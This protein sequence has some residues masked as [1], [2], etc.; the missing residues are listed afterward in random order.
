[1]TE[2]AWVDVESMT[3]NVGDILR[4][5]HDAYDSKVGNIHNGRIVRVIEVKDGDVHVTTADY[6]TPY[7]SRARHAPYR[8]ERK[9]VVSESNS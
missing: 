8:L 7:L 4:V 3:I 9:V 5:K 1:M 6:K 2:T